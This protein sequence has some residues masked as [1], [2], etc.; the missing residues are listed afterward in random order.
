MKPQLMK[1]LQILENR[2]KPACENSCIAFLDESDDGQ[3]IIKEN[4]YHRNGQAS[5]RS[6]TIIATSAEEAAELYKEPEGCT[7]CILFIKDFGEMWPSDEVAEK[8]AEMM[9]TEEL[10]LMVAEPTA[11]GTLID[12]NGCEITSEEYDIFFNRIMA[13]YAGNLMHEMGIPK[14]DL[15]KIESNIKESLIK[16]KDE[17]E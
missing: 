4:I 1:R 15:Q 12:G 7:D 6:Y 14:Q 17:E 13:K 10:K 11:C 16:R 5:Q 8:L 9:T 2:Y 3:Y